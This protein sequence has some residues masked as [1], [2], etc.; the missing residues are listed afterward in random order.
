MLSAYVVCCIHLLTSLTYV[1]IVVNIVNPVQT[2]VQSG[3]TLFV[4][5]ASKVFQQTTKKTVFVVI[6]ALTI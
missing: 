1:S 5:E 2:A 4:K 3:A 6:G